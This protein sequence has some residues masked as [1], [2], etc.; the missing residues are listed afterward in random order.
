MSKIKKN[1]KIDTQ[2]IEDMLDE[3]LFDCYDIMTLPSKL[4]L[5]NKGKILKVYPHPICSENGYVV[6]GVQYLPHRSYYLPDALL[7]RVIYWDDLLD[8][9]ATKVKKQTKSKVKVLGRP[10]LYTA[11][12]A[13]QW[14]EM[15]KS[16]MTLKKIEELTGV[17]S[18]NIT[19]Y[20]K[21]YAIAV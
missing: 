12:D 3:V 6:L 20:L 1:N 7:D 9:I 5:T 10:A 13:R 2:L 15:K 14:A 8:A 17:K 21:K 19:S 11:E 16:G 18:H 4:R